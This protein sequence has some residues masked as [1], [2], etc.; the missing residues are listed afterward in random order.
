MRY[1]NRLLTCLEQNLVCVKPS[2]QLWCFVFLLCAL[3]KA[4]P[5]SGEGLSLWMKLQDSTTFPVKIL[6]LCQASWVEN[7]SSRPELCVSD[8]GINTSL[9]QMQKA[10]KILPS[11]AVLWRSRAVRE[12]MCAPVCAAQHGG[13]PCLLL[14]VLRGEHSTVRA[15]PALKSELFTLACQQAPS[16]GVYG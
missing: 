12:T 7:S 6:I 8:P 13:H 16:L 2:P 3:H 10:T 4:S 11:A 1:R 5:L 15:A 9:P 14:W